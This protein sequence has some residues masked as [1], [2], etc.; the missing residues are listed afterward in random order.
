MKKIFIIAGEPSGDL[1]A[2]KLIRE[3]KKLIPDIEFTGIGGDLMIAEGLKPLIHL[4]KVSVVGFWEVAK[5]YSFFNKLIKQCQQLLKNGDYDCF[6]PVD[7]PGFNI[8][9]ANFAK[10]INLPV[11]YYIAPQLWAWGENRAVK[12][13]NC[14]D[15][16]FVVFPFE[17]EYFEGFG[18]NTEFIGHPLL[19]M[20]CFQQPFKNLEQ[21]E[22]RF[23]FMPGS[24]TQELKKHSKIIIDIISAMRKRFPDYEY[25][26]IKSKAVSE[27]FYQNLN[28]QGIHLS[29]D[30]FGLMLNSKAGIIKT[31]TSTLEACLAGLPFAMFYKTSWLTYNIGK[32]LIKLPYLSIANIL[33]NR[34]VIGEFIQSDVKPD[35]IAD[36]IANIV[37]SPDEF[38]KMQNEF[39]RIKEILGES[40]A[41]KRAAE[42]IAKNI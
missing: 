2:A 14:V 42:I 29:E 18:I 17:K 31:G 12:L 39:Q 35:K 33:T 3:L 34:T 4:E 22:N 30:N 11:Y 32:K 36:Y 9:I 28:S 41:S 24:R 21:R 13:K 38:D 1:H 16:L 10:Q 25:T 23:L 7:Y 15:K 27:H 37:N 20:E 6:I 26:V 5:R 19:D 40:G 8:R